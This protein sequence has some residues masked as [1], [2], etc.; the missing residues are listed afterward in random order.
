MAEYRVV[1]DNFAGFEVQA[2][3]WW[4]PFWLECDFCNTHP[5]V[6]AAE[7]WAERHAQRTVKYLGRLVRA[8]R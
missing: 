8:D 2:R 7:R 3:R 1:E 5:T 4:W 6:E